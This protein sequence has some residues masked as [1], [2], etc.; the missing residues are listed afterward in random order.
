MK[1]LNFAN[2]KVSVFY[3]PLARANTNSE[4]Q[5]V[6]SMLVFAGQGGKAT[7]PFWN[8]QAVALLTLLIT[9]LKTQEEE[10]QNLYN[11][12]HLLNEMGGNSKSIDLLFS[13]YADPV[14]FSEY[15]SFISY[16]EKIVSGVVASCKASLQTFADL[17][18]AQVTSKDTLDMQEFRSKK[19]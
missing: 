2:P 16:D 17:S 12:R 10:F 9:I 1:V 5:K 19:V 7:D 3:N 6:A 15:K 4:I 14:T 11:V 13:K 8:T 18:I